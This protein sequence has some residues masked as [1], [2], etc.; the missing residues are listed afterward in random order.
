M[1]DRLIFIK[2]MQRTALFPYI[3]F[4]VFFHEPFS[5]CLAEP[6]GISPSFVMHPTSYM[7]LLSCPPFRLLA[8][9]LLFSK[10]ARGFLTSRY[11]G[12]DEWLMEAH[13]HTC[14]SIDLCTFDSEAHSKD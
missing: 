5:S 13:W 8:Y 11:H 3:C 6:S 2:R 10:I 12:V 14:R 9:P 1:N 4:N 7:H